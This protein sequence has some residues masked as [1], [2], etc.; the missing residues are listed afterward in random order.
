MLSDEEI[1]QALERAQ[2]RGVAVRVI[3]EEHPFGGA[4]GEERVFARLEQADIAVRWSNPAFRLSHIKTF[5]IDAE[6]AIIMNQ[7]L[8]KT[9]FTGNRE[10]GAITTRP[11]EVAQAAAIFEADWRRTAEPPDGPLV[12][13]PTTSRRTLLNIIEG[14][15]TS[16]DIYAEVVRDEEI[17]A[18][19]EQAPSRGVTVRLIV[20]N[21][22]EENDRGREERAR[23]AARGVQVRL[24]RGLYVHAK[25]V[26][27]DGKRAFVGSQNFTTASLDLNRELGI[28]LNDRIT[29]ARLARTFEEDFR[30]GR[31][32]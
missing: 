1:L 22:S 2:A 5:V 13:S 25:M 4:G 14:A 18:A 23:L 28:L 27:V 26:L 31:E 8:T 15:T 30:A 17:V 24:A 16:I 20:S 10:F 19:L 11:R 32:E 12:V 3:M 29:I 7:N 21:D 6:V 9:S